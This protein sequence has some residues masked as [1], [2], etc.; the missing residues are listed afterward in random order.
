MILIVA[1]A[2]SAGVMYLVFGFKSPK[3]TVTKVSVRGMNLT[4]VAPISP[5]FDVSIR[6]ENPNGEVDIYY[7]KDSAVSIFYNGVG[8][9]DGVLADLYQPKKNVTVLQVTLTG[10]DVVLDGAAKTALRNAQRRG[11][12]PLFVNVEAPIIFEVGSVKTWEVVAHVKCDVVLDMLNV[13]G[14]IVSKSCDY[15]MRLW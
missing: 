9:G 3:Y 11:K 10:S 2:V 7:L 14:K 4:S 5:G 1:A 13:K 15:S 6:A 8:L 12:V